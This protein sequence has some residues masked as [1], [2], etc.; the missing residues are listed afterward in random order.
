MIILMDTEKSFV[1]IDHLL[2]IKLNKLEIKEN[3]FHLRKVIYEKPTADII[4]DGKRLKAFPRSGKCPGS[5]F[6]PFLFD[7]ILEGPLESR[8]GNKTVQLDS[9]MKYKASRLER[10]K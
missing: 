7:I 5:L 9:K 3:F 6:S 1:K 8:M 2:M 4:L 10:K